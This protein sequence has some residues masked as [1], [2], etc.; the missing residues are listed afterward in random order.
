MTQLKTEN[1]KQRKFYFHFDDEI[2]L[3]KDL[4][5]Q[6][7]K[8]F[9]FSSGVRL[10]H[11]ANSFKQPEKE[12]LKSLMKTVCFEANDTSSW[13]LS[14]ISNELIWA[15][16]QAIQVDFASERAKQT[17]LVRT[18]GKPLMKSSPRK[19]RKRFTKMMK[20]KLLFSSSKNKRKKQT[21]KILAKWWNAFL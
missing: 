20:D 11:F 4:C 5:R 13:F 10:L 2:K 3:A 1:Q 21:S 7:V 14:M 16:L 9:S 6:M 15:L 18:L 8:C 17:K 12:L 19:L